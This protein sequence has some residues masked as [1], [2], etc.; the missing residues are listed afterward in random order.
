[1]I[2][3]YRG[4][5]P[6]QPR[7]S[8]AV[9]ADAAGRAAAPP[10]RTQIGVL[11][12][13]Q[14]CVLSGA[15]FVFPFLPILVRTVG[16]RD[17]AAVALW[18]GAAVAASQ[19]AQAFAAPLWG[20]LADRVG[21]KPMLVRA[22][23]ALAILL[24]AT[25]LSPNVY[26]LVLFRALT[27]VFAGSVA[28]TNA[29][30]STIAPREKL[31]HS[32]GVLQS[33]YY[34]GTMSGPALGALF[35]SGFGVR[36]AFFVAAVMPALAGIG[37]STLIREQFTRRP[38][39]TR[40][41]GTKV[42]LREAGVLKPLLTLV[43]M[44]LLAQG[45]GIGLSAAL[46]LRAGALAGSAHAAEA[47]GGAATL[48]ACC[49]AVAALSVARVSR[50]FSYRAVLTSLALLGALGY[51]LVAVAPSFAV[52]LLCIS[53]GGLAVGGMLPSINAMLGTVAPAEV[54]AEVFGYSASAMAAG[55]GTAPLLAGLLAARFGTP[56]PFVMVA[57]IDL[58][59]AAWALKRLGPRSGLPASPRPTPQLEAVAPTEPMAP[60][61]T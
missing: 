33:G 28:A 50:R 40:R 46:P 44:A 26:F 10:W 30:V 19:L 51:G 6:V 17:P 35:V 47:V 61:A 34:I 3:Y 20:R 13:S 27:G 55:G 57:G 25:G 48:Q 4:R 60:L 38:P 16:V 39:G 58:A 2:R 36:P 49:A 21:R 45:V 1:M 11:W 23:F 43:V 32:L 12:F 14:F 5:Q 15:T 37:V 53:V 31:T 56:A 59:L 52:M 7:T 18:T 41:R 8:H 29:L 54:R 42:V 22:T 9:A 24:I